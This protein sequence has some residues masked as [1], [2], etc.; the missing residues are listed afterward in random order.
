MTE[1][2]KAAADA[3]RIHEKAQESFDSNIK[4]LEAARRKAKKA[5]DAEEQPPQPPLQALTI[6][7]LFARP[8]P[9][10]VVD[11]WFPDTGL[12]QIVGHPGAL[13]TFFALDAS[14]SIACGLTHFFGYT[15]TR[16]GPVLYIAAEG[17]GAFQYRI[18]AWCQEHEF[19]PLTIPFRIIPLPVNLRDENLQKELLAVVEQMQPIF[20]VVDTL[21]RCSPGAEENSA[22]DMGEVIN[23]CTL[24]QR[25]ARSTVAFIH[26]PAKSS[27]NGGGRGSG[28]VFGAIDTEIQLDMDEKEDALILD[29]RNVKVVCTKQKD[30]QR[31]VPLELMGCVIPIYNG[32]GLQMVH[33]SGRPV[34]SLVMRLGSSKE[35]REQRQRREEE[36]DQETRLSVLRAIQKYP[37]ATNITKLR[38]RMGISQD[39]VL[40]AIRQLLREGWIVEGKRGEPFEIKESGLKALETEL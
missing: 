7:E 30:D 19:D 40:A 11:Q 28:A 24:L 38:N 25:P 32:H 17:G 9:Q 14:L 36:K 21:A 22:K 12:I 26:H 3:L 1:Q 15:I 4:R 29:S 33:E 20:I 10:Y 2:E 27:T 35:M 34:T 8:Q 39:L 31:P 16:Y 5:L 23:F 6:Q 37:D 13:K 18:R